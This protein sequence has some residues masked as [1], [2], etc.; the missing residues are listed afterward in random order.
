TSYMVGGPADI[1]ALPE[2]ID[3][4]AATVQFCADHGI[5]YFFIGTGANVLVADRGFRG[6]VL[7]VSRS[8]TS[9]VRR[10]VFVDVEAGVL[11]QNLIMFC[12]KNGL[13][14]VEYLSGIPGTAGGALIMNAGVDKHEIGAVVESVSILDSNGTVATVPQDAISFSYRAA[15]ELQGKTIIGCRLKLALSDSEQLKE[16]RLAQIRKRCAAQPLDL[17][18][19]GSV[20][21]RPPGYYVGKLVEDLGL[22]GYRYGN[23][24]IS[25]KHGGFILNRGGATAHDILY[26]IKMVRRKVHE[27]YAIT[28]EP[29]VRLA[30]L[31]LPGPE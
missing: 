10:G 30:G 16:T 19:C 20:F 23:A 15:P 4:L 29:E 9:M 13:Q 24:M 11:L 31:D 17:P 2:T 22:K 1:F 18:S 28:L 6:V 14:G 12:E 25:D 3:E 26:L 21:K 7:T 8:L 5:P 27:R